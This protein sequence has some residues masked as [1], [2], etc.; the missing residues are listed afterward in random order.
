VT[1]HTLTVTECGEVR[2][3]HHA[4]LAWVAELGTTTTRRASHA[5]PTGRFARWIFHAIRS[6]VSDES[7][8][9]AITRRWPVKWQAN[10]SPVGGGILGTFSRREEAIA[11]E[12]RWLQDHGF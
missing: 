8:L 12:V 9:A 5:E 3:V 1:T 2:C 6:R 7:L 4:A 11:A 10:L